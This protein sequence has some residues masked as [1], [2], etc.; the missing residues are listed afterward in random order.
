M[1]VVDTVMP[2][3]AARAKL[4]PG[5]RCLV[6]HSGAFALTLL[7]PCLCADRTVVGCNIHRAQY[8]LR[9][10]LCFP[11]PI[12]SPWG[13]PQSIRFAS[14][15]SGMEKTQRASPSRL[16]DVARIDIEAVVRFQD[17]PGDTATRDA[18][19]IPSRV[20]R[21]LCFLRAGPFT[22]PQKRAG[23]VVIIIAH[24]PPEQ[25][26]PAPS[27]PARRRRFWG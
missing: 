5:V 26:L 3:H 16:R 14:K 18:Y 27:P 1:H 15:R 9:S 19:R 25:P 21:T 7:K 2:V 20:R 22:G 8:R 10:T 23:A 13:K 17:L 24:T 4:W 12:L 6:T 11:S